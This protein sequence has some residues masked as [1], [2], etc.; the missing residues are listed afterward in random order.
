M[1]YP[2]GSKI[3]SVIT[4]ALRCQKERQKSP[5]QSQKRRYGDGSREPERWQPGRD[6]L[7]LLALRMEERATGQGVRA[8]PGAEKGEGA[9]SPLDSPGGTLAGPHRDFS[10]GGPTLNSLPV[11]LR[12]YTFALF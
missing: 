10:P 9:D 3:I 6:S 2:S 12:D 11:E 4:K 7:E 1:D 8:A 5:C